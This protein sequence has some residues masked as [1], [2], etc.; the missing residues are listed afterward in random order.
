MELVHYFTR[1]FDHE[2]S[3][4]KVAEYSRVLSAVAAI[5]NLLDQVPGGKI[6]IRD[7][8]KIGLDGLC[9][10]DLFNH[11][12][13]P[14]TGHC[15]TSMMSQLQLVA[16]INGRDIPIYTSPFYNSP[17]GCRPLRLWG[18]K[19]TMGEGGTL[20]EELGRLRG[21]LDNL[22][23]FHFSDQITVQVSTT[24]ASYMVMVKSS[25]N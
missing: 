8:F 2:G 12:G 16:N 21:E 22:A 9:G 20:Q 5:L 25:R 13:E 19:E 1:Q 7:H 4:C 23:P 6:E 14:G 15:L 24:L 11:R 18:V 17:S 3:A 10:L